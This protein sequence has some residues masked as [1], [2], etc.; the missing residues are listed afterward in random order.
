MLRKL[1]KYGIAPRHIILFIPVS[2]QTA[3]GWI[4]GHIARPNKYQL[5]KLQQMNAAVDAA[6]KYGELPVPKEFKGKVR[7]KYIETIIRK[8]ME[9]PGRELA[10]VT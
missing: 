10:R 8:Y 1:V 3:S 5:E 4:N 9:G 6:V 2:R 7:D